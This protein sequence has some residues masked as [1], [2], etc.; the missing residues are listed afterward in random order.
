MHL[1][2]MDGWGGWISPVLLFL[3]L[4]LAVQLFTGFPQRYSRLGAANQSPSH[5]LSTAIGLAD[6]NNKTHTEILPRLEATAREV[7]ATKT[8]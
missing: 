1:E 2:F 7:A 3:L 6:T 4:E 8:H 5:A